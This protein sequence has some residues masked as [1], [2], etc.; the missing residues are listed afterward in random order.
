[1]LPL[2]IA[3]AQ[4]EFSRS[5]STRVY[6][7]PA[8]APRPAPSKASTKP[9][10]RRRLRT[11]FPVNPMASKVPICGARCSTPKTKRSPMRMSAASTRKKLRPMN[12]PPKSLAESPATASVRTSRKRNPICAGSNFSRNAVSISVRSVALNRNR[13]VVASP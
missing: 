12:R 5:T 3:P 11:V 1:M 4:S 2:P 13:M 7:K 8:H 6:P 9:S 10:A